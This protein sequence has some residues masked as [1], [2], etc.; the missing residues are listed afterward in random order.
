MSE[1][2]CEVVQGRI[3]DLVSGRVVGEEADGIRS[4]LSAC[5]DCREVSDLV[6]L[7]REGRPAAPEGLAGRIAGAVRFRRRSVPR[8]WW[9]LAAAS[10]AALAL[11]IGVLSDPEPRVNV[12]AFV[13]EAQPSALFFSDDGLIA[14]APTLEDLSEEALLTLLEEMGAGPSGGAA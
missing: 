12:P 5:P 4:H 11:G 14:G 1:S 6:S 7:L 2:R 8:P 10:I 13:A 9:G 3:P